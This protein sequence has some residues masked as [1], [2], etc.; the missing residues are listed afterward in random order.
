MHILVAF[1][2]ESIAVSSMTVSKP[3]NSST[4]GFHILNL[5]ALL[6]LAM[7][8]SWVNIWHPMISVTPLIIALTVFL[9]LISYSLVNADLRNIHLTG[10]KI[11]K[12]T[13]YWDD[14]S[15]DPNAIPF[16][17]NITLSNLG[18]FILAP[19]LVR[20]YDYNCLSLT[21]LPTRLSTQ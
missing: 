17:S 4:K 5:T 10:R 19:T 13:R 15:F 8:N 20:Y 2:I 21:E 7:A 3:T 18:Y 1:W 14:A 9:K 11:E 16:P 6:V 12:A